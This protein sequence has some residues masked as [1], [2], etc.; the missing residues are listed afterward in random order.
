MTRRRT[1]VLAAAAGLTV[2]ALVTNA[3]WTLYGRL[4]GEPFWHGLPASYYA[5]RAGRFFTGGDPPP[6]AVGLW[7]RRNLPK[8]VAGHFWPTCPPFTDDGR[9]TL[10][11]D[12][13]DVI[14]VLLHMTHDPKANVRLWAANLL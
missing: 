5:A 6:S 3:H 8:P 4:R 7:C 9:V 10:T 12:D 14:P 13:G 11:H 1:T 2:A